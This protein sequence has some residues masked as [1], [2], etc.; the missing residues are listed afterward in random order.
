MNCEEARR[1]IAQMS[2]DEL[3]TASLDGHASACPDCSQ[4]LHDMRHL[5]EGLA[6]LTIPRPTAMTPPKLV[7][8]A[9]RSRVMTLLAA[10]LAMLMV[11]ALAA[12]V[13]TNYLTAE[14]ASGPGTRDAL[15]YTLG[16]DGSKKVRSQPS[17]QSK[18]EQSKPLPSNQSRN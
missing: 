12:F 10:T 14:D 2:V 8:G 6:S 1:Q 3:R 18:P 5:S 15:F 17:A 11:G 13:Y 16:K 7:V 4:F 9:R